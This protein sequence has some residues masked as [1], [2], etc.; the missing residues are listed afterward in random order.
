MIYNICIIKV[1]IKM[2]RS[3]SYRIALG[4]TLASMCLLCQ[5]ITGVFPVFYI[6]MPMIC[7]ILVTVMAA[8]TNTWWGFLMYL[9]VSLLSL[10]VTP[11]KDAAFIFIMFFGHYPLLRPCLSRI[12]IRPAA[13]LLKA[14]IFNVCI[15]AYFFMTVYLFGMD[16]LL[17]EMGEFGKYGGL[18]LLGLANM[19]FA[20]YDYLMDVAMEVYRKKVHPKISSKL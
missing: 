3:L 15:I 16:E 20:S 10:F 5:F 4:G 14:L 12:R 17:E 8:E 13:Y 11:N 19:M 2:K 7:G 9:A 6:I 1:I 18:V